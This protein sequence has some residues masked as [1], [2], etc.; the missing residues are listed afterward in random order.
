MNGP[1]LPATLTRAGAAGGDSGSDVVGRLAMA[2]RPGLLGA[3]RGLAP[4]GAGAAVC[5]FSTFGGRGFS[6]CDRCGLRPS[7]PAS[8]RGPERLEPLSSRD[9]VIDIAPDVV[10]ERGHFEK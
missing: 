5:G 2:G 7:W 10:T 4:D 6:V 3:G 9:D 1:S 8:E